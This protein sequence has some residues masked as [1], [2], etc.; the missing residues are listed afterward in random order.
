MRSILA[1]P[2]LALV[3]TV[4]EPT[5]GPGSDAAP[6]PMPP[7]PP[8]AEVVA[9]GLDNP[10]GIT[11]DADGALWIAE[12][13]GVPP[14][15]AAPCLPGPEG[16]EVCYDT[17][18]AI[19][20]VD[21][22]TSEQVVTGLRSIAQRS[23]MNASGPH[24]VAI[25]ADGTVYVVVG[26]GGDPATRADNEAGGPEQLGRLFTLDIDSGE[27]T[28]VADI[29]GY[30]TSDNPDGGLVDSNPFSLV[31]LDDGSLA[32]TDAGGNSLLQ[33]TADGTISTLA[34]FPDRQV[35]TS[36]GSSEVPMNAVPTGF[37]VGSDGDFYVGQL[38]GFPFPADGANVYRVAA[39]GGDPEVAA[40]GFTN[41]IDVAVADNGDLYVLEINSGGLLNVDPADPS[42][43]TG[44]L[45]RISAD[46]ARDV[47]VPGLVFPSAVAL[48]DDG[49]IYVTNN[50]VIAG[51]GQVLGIAGEA[52]AGST[53]AT[54][55]DTEMAEAPAT[56]G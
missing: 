44:E 39:G 25:T 31:A 50:S 41:I 53:P 22:D 47:V 16:P 15:A 51:A 29:A 52:S 24:D 33:V 26:F 23:G 34:V 38:T 55:G 11:I 19:T 46:G 2:A 49:T 20:R 45:S 54:T 42:T 8:G 27:L 7:L 3:A 12:A 35:E 9:D 4:P 36:D 28:E 37:A 5:P 1:I 10:R 6:P 40:D 18:G 13:G 48:A 30:E 14:D 43:M 21:G 56:T 17:G 32:V